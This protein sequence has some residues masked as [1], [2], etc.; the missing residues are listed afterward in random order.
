MELAVPSRPVL[1]LRAWNALRSRGP[2]YTWHKLLRRS[3]RAYPT[4][5]RRLLYADPRL[6]WT[7]RGGD[8]YFREQEGQRARSLRAE[9]LAERLAVYQP[10]SILEVGCG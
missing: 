5:K 4:W 6:Y 10:A 3:L 7:L 2:R 1:A 8:D 9:W